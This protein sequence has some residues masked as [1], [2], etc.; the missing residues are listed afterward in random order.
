MRFAIYARYSPSG[1]QNPKSIEDQIGACS[2]RIVREGGSL[3][4]STA[5]QPHPVLMPHSVQN[6][7]SCSLICGS[8]YSMR[9][10]PRISIASARR[11]LG[12]CFSCYSRRQVPALRSPMI[13]LVPCVLLIPGPYE[14]SPAIRLMV[15]K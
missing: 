12:R 4:R 11:S 15:A 7:N 5:M 3:V 6:T 10:S 8:D 14:S 1:L 13:A 9:R 2:V